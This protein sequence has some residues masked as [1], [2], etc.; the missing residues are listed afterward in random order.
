MLPSRKKCSSSEERKEVQFFPERNIRL[1][2]SRL[3]KVGPGWKKR[4]SQIKVPQ[5]VNWSNCCKFGRRC[6]S[7]IRTSETPQHFDH[8]IASYFLSAILC[9]NQDFK[10]R[11]I[12]A[13]KTEVHLERSEIGSRAAFRTEKFLTCKLLAKLD[14]I[15]FQFHKFF[16]SMRL[17]I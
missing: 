5:L 11:W 14:G 13:T 15:M 10:F 4:D 8:E 12:F 3:L 7:W 1:K 9:K 2:A 16:H 6:K 17:D